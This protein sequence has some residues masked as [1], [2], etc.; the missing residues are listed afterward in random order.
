MCIRKIVLYMVFAVA[1]NP[2]VKFF[3]WSPILKPPEMIL[4]PEKFRGPILTSSTCVPNFR[5]TFQLE[6]P[7]IRRN[8]PKC[9]IWTSLL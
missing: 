8:P 9:M 4:T 6:V 5:V 7:Q 1:H 2:G 3:L